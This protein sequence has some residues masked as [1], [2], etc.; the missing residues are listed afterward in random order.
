MNKKLVW[1][2]FAYLCECN[3][4]NLIDKAIWWSKDELLGNGEYF[5]AQKSQHYPWIKINKNK[6][7][8]FICRSRFGRLQKL[9]IL[10]VK[11]N[12]SWPEG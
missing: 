9:I 10:W 12:K 8:K 3:F 11:R 6:I 2:T 4:A 7:G 1:R 5:E